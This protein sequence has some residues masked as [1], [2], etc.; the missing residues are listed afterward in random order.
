M[1][2]LNSEKWKRRD[3]DTM[4]HTCIEVDVK[5]VILIWEVL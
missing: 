1:R 2:P 5:I 3:G 4:T